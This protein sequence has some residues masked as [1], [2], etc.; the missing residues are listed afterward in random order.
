M[1]MEHIKLEEGSPAEI[2]KQGRTNPA[3]LDV[4]PEKWPRWLER[5]WESTDSSLPGPHPS[6]PRVPPL[7]LPAS[8]LPHLILR[9]A[10]REENLTG[11]KELCVGVSEGKDAALGQ[12]RGQLSPL[13]VQSFLLW[14]RDRCQAQGPA[15]RVRQGSPG[16]TAPL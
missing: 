2:S 15:G 16:L 8:P 13:H 14:E 6:I 11:I 3:D 10:G 12:L 7:S 4:F 5:T 9:R 1:G